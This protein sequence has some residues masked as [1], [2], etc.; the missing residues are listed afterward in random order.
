MRNP[1]HPNGYIPKIVH[2][3]SQGN[4]DKAQYFVDR[5]VATYGPL[6][7]DERM[8]IAELYYK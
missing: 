5:H 7:Y 3:L 2:H 6:T 8:T 1:K 4:I